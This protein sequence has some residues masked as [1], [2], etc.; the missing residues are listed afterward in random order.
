MHKFFCL[1][2][3]TTLCAASF[4]KPDALQQNLQKL[5]TGF[6]GRL[7]I[8]AL[9]TTS[10]NPICVNGDQAFSLQSVMKLVVSVAVMDAV[11]RGKMRLADVVIVR[12]DDAGPGPQD[13]ADF[14]KSKG[15][16]K[17]TV[18]ELI[19]RAIVD[20]DSTSI[21][22]LITR[23]GGVNAVQDFLRRKN[24]KGVRIDRN[25]RDLQSETVGLSWH[26]AYADAQKLETA[27]ANLSIKKRE[28][29][30]QQYLKDPRDTAT[31]VGMVTFLQALT[32]EQLLSKASTNKILAIMS[33]TTTGPDRL[34]AG[35]PRGWSIG[36]KTGT[37]R[38]WKGM[39]AVTNDVG[40]LTAPDGAKIAVAV[41]VA[42]SKQSKEQ[43]A[44]MIA[45]AAKIITGAYQAPVK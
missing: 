18:E 28:E 24:I 42:E 12:P 25:E 41:F 14:V 4:V 20:S 35:V 29:A 9:E 33:A 27:A 5:T 39:N 21:D 10:T 8:C 23:I 17:V 11:D 7:G 34:R 6:D 44:G 2:A 3:L 37:S 26:A 22:I 15:Q 16:V 1:L 30:W 38:S 32:T 45:K 40:I 36:H 43:R 31:P 13:F 19:R